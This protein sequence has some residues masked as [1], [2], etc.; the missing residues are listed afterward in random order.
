MKAAEHLY[1]R[2][3]TRYPL[4]SCS[5]ITQW[6]RQESSKN[7]QQPG[8]VWSVVNWCLHW[9]H[10][11]Q[12]WGSSFCNLFPGNRLYA[13]LAD[14]REKRLGK[15]NFPL[16]AWMFYWAYTTELME[17]VNTIGETYKGARKWMRERTGKSFIFILQS[18]FNF[19]LHHSG[20]DL[21]GLC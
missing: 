7:T 8:P 13:D 6:N 10:Y 17:Q 9:I 18:N 2:S 15:P 16:N 19:F 11:Q 20:L 12:A 4:S 1:M 21:L 5:G 3:Y 14:L